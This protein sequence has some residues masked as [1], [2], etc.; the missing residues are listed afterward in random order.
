MVGESAK[1][2]YGSK[3]TGTVERDG[4]EEEFNLAELTI[5]ED[6]KM[7]GS[8]KDYAGDF[9]FEGIHGKGEVNCT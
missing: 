5:T 3:W 8:G 6:G 4:N 1:D 9:K 7:K 2:R